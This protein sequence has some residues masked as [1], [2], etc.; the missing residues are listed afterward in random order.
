MA[1]IASRDELHI[2]LRLSTYPSFAIHKFTRVNILA[3]VTRRLR[4]AWELMSAQPGCTTASFD[5]ALIDLIVQKADGVFLWVNLVVTQLIAS[6]EE[7]AESKELRRQLSDLPKDL[8]DLYARIVAK[9]PDNAVHDAINFLGLYD[10]NIDPRGTSAIPLH[11][12][13]LWEF[14]AADQDPLTAVSCKAN[15]EEG[16]HQDIQS[17]RDQCLRMKRRI[18]RCCKGLIHV[19]DSDDIHTAEV[20]LL[21]RT[22]EEFI[23]KDVKF[24]DLV[25]RADQQL[26]RDPNTSLIAMALR[27]LKGDSD[28]TPKW[29]SWLSPEDDEYTSETE[30]RE[31]LISIEE[32]ADIVCCFFFFAAEA[33]QKSSGFSCRPYIDELDRVL[34]HLCPNWAANYYRTLEEE[35]HSD[36]NTDVLSLAVV[37]NLDLYLKEEPKINGRDLFHRSQR[38]LLC[39]AFDLFSF[40]Y[41]HGTGM[42]DF[43][44]SN[45]AGPNEQFYSFLF[46]T[47]EQLQLTTPWILA[48]RNAFHHDFLFDESFMLF[49]PCIQRL[50]KYGADPTQRVSRAILEVGLALDE[51]PKTLL[52]TTTFH[53]IL[54]HL[55]KIEA[56]KQLEI[57]ELLLD[58]CK[59]FDAADS[60][61]TTISAWADMM[62]KRLGRLVRKGIAERMTRKQVHALWK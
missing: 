48:V 27:L 47:D 12:C 23:T 24:D 19:E 17:R 25:A 8:G 21:H 57:I 58:H 40:V 39:Y 42:I 60:D 13:T 55:P 4:T 1:C 2:R 41:K 18:Q 46:F 29:T 34:S 51:I 9:I 45:G 44:L 16:F 30:S 52:Y 35:S 49:L 38:P 31:K 54:S 15:F 26:V 43:L 33:A 3:Y 53:F 22:V 28:Y 37:H 14:C 62:G 59:D 36:W 20:G 5:Q 56:R 32:H 10:H 6:I 61:G 50:L 7:E 11:V